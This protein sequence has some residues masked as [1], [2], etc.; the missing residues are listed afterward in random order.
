MALYTENPLMTSCTHSISACLST[1]MAIL[2]A[3]WA[4]REGFRDIMDGVAGDDIQRP[5]G[6][7]AGARAPGAGDSDLRVGLR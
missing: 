2:S 4:R 5:A 7:D 6:V 3:S 1:A